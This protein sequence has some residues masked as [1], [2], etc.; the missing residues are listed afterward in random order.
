MKRTY[1]HIDLN[2]RRRIARWRHAGLSIDT[3]AEKLGRHRSTIFR[4]VRRNVYIDKEWPE[5]SG[6]HCVTAH[7]MAC[8]SGGGKVGHGSGGIMLLRAE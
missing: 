7:D 3:I 8:E 6:Y 5:L 1:S 2:E 4:E